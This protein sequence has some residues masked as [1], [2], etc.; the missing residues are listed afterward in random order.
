VTTDLT[1]TTTNKENSNMNKNTIP[2]H[3]TPKVLDGI[4][5]RLV[6]W[7]ALS[8]DPHLSE[9]I[10]MTFDVNKEWAAAGMPTLQIKGTAE[11]IIDR[12]ERRG[13]DG[14]AISP[15]YELLAR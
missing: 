15:L 6:E 5:E 1:T 8:H 14:G 12:L 11:V 2:R 13:V 3:I 10:D 4:E 9:L 7:Q